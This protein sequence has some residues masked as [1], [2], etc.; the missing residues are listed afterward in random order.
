M[1]STFAVTGVASGIG[2]ELARILR[3]RGHSVIGLD[4]QEPQGAV[5][6]FVKLDLGDPQSIVS[7]LNSV[8]CELD[9]LCNNA[10]LPP[11]EGWEALILQVNFLGQRQLT[12]GLLK[13][14]K[15]GASIVNMAS[16]AGQGWR[17]SIDQVKQLSAIKA[18][19]EL[20]AFVKDQSIDPTRAYN[21]SKE[22][23]ILWTLAESE[24]MA[25]QGIRI[26]SLSPG[27][28]ATGI[29]DDFR[30]AFGDQMARNVERAGRPGKP[31]EVAEVAAFLLSP[32]SN[33]IKG[34][35][36]AIDG[37]MGAFNI[38]DRLDLSDLVFP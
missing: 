38:S 29:L 36:I 17:D 33:W 15:E 19:D 28:I 16:R 25:R 12:K 9:G 3:E 10:G 24:R 30:K 34:T 20:N 2:A 18:S 22:A 4:I 6:Q 7:A 5:N 21:L 1:G 11:R 31:E 26:N 14:L 37:G 35:D 32:S 8:D 23:M 13:K 27:G